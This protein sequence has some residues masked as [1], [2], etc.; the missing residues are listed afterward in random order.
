[1]IG[2]DDEQQLS[3]YQI[4]STHY[5]GNDHQPLHIQILGTAGAGKSYL[6]QAIS[7]NNWLLTGTTGIAAFNIGGITLHSGSHL[8]V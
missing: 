2:Q 8:P 1:M 4:M 7:Q 5:T 3:A 6:I